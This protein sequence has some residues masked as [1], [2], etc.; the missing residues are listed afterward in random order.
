MTRLDAHI[1]DQIHF[2]E[3]LFDH[4]SWARLF[5]VDGHALLPDIPYTQDFELAKDVMM[6]Y[7]AAK[8]SKCLLFQ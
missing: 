3:T 2:N 5:D 8:W 1:G 7:M 4:V 6:E